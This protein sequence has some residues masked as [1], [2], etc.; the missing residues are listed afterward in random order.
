MIALSPHA[1]DIL[2]ALNRPCHPLRL[3][4]A[5]KSAIYQLVSQRLAERSACG[6]RLTI[7]WAGRNILATIG[8]PS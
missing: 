8:G 3:H 7:T 4:M 6:Q 2:T 1:L 5:H